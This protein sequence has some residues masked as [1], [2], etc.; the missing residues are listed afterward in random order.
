MNAK[1]VAELYADL[2]RIYAEL[3]GELEGMPA[4]D[5]RKRRSPRPISKPTGEV[6][7]SKTDLQL[8]DSLLRRHIGR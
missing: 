3:A 1:R 5:V 4:N 2:S 6:T 7:P 8:A